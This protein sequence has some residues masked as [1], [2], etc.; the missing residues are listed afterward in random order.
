[1]SKRFLA[2]FLFSVITQQNARLTRKLLASNISK[3]TRTTV[4]FNHNEIT[5]EYLR[6]NALHSNWQI[7][8]LNIV[9]I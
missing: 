8:T 7:K 2:N 5:D 1:M 9:G 4:R 3:E 6:R